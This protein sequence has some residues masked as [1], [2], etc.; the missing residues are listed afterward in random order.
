MGVADLE[1]LVAP[2]GRRLV[3]RTTLYGR[4]AA[5]SPV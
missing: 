2:T 4:V 1:A 5:G 3:Q